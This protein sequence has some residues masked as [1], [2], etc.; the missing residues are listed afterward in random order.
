MVSR[1]PFRVSSI[2]LYAMD[3]NSTM[4]ELHSFVYSFLPQRASPHTAARRP[5][6]ETTACTRALSW[7]ALWWSFRLLS[8]TSGA[9]SAGAGAGSA[10]A[11]EASAAAAARRTT[12]RS[13]LG[14]GIGGGAWPDSSSALKWPSRGRRRHFGWN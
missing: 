8:V 12:T 1:L 2:R 6:H 3:R 10:R 5:T 13:A 11:G 14:G 9:A 4:I 7:I